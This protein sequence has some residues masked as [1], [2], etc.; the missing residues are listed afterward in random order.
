MVSVPVRQ[1]AVLYGG[2]EY[3]IQQLSSWQGSIEI[4][5][6]FYASVA[7]ISTIPQGAT[8]RLMPRVAIQPVVGENV[9]HIITVKQYMTKPAS[10]EFNFMAQWNNNIPM[11]MRTM[12]G[13]VEK[14]T[15]GMVY[16]KLHGD[17]IA[18]R[19]YTCMCCGRKLTN[20]VSQFFGVGPECGGHNY[21]NPFDSDEE[22]KQA[23]DAYRKVLVN[24]TWEGWI[25]RSAITEDRIK[26]EE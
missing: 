7:D 18:D 19:M 15:K 9:E 6:M 21:V 12:V 13:T 26:G 22:L 4:D 5:G 3:M 8:I 10:P 23:V 25:I 2:G 14:E 11:P 24:T 1:T 17:Y 16:M 20:P